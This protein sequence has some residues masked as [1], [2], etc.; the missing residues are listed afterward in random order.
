[1]L[2]SAVGQFLRA[3][4]SHASSTFAAVLRI[5]KTH[6]SFDDFSIAGSRF[7]ERIGVGRSRAAH[8][9]DVVCRR[10]VLN[11]RT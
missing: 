4:P 8:I 11:Q 5:A 6:N 2:L 7:D 1:M 10:G 9:L 3:Q